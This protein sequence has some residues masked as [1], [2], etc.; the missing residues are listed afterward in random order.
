MCMQLAAGNIIPAHSRVQ[1]KSFL[2]S[3]ST[4]ILMRDIYT[5]GV[6]FSFQMKFN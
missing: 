1:W 5:D 2:M 3:M 6:N 4:V